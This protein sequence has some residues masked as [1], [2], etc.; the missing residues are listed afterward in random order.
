MACVWQH[1]KSVNWFARYRGAGGIAVN[2]ST[3]SP[4]KVEAL[5]IATGWQ[6]EAARERDRQK[7]D[8]SPGGISDAIARAERLARQGR[9]DTLAARDIINDLLV[10]AG[11]ATLDTVTSRSWC[12]GWEKSK[13]GSVKEPS[14][15]KYRQVCRDWLSF[16]NSKADKPMESISKSDVTAYRDRL[17]REGLSSGTVNHSVKLLRG[18]YGAA[19]E[20]EYLGRNPFAG[21]DPLRRDAHAARRQPFTSAEVEKLVKTAIGDWKGLIILAASTGLRLMDAARLEWRSVDMDAAVIRITT[22]KTGAKLEL[23]IHPDLVA[24]L[25]GEPRGI[26]AAPLFPDLFGK[27]GAG[28]SGLSMAFKALMKRAKIG[29]GTVGERSGRGRAMSRKSFHSLRH[30]AATEMAANGVRAEVAR[31]ITGHADEATHANYVTADRDVLR[32]AVNAIRLVAAKLP[33]SRRRRRR[34]A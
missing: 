11:E 27:V 1:P 18:V 26:G 34:A 12:D 10:A 24:W 14:R 21:V 16:L 20:Q 23:P 31:A 3:G 8:V 28:K 29:D 25:R 19:V 30:F 32:G 15:L 33:N 2:R 6:I 17:A 4:D 5:R 7:A 22:A 13:A 9:L